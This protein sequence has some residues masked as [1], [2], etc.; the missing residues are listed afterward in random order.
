MA[1]S[2][3]SLKVLAPMPAPL[4]AGTCRLVLEAPPSRRLSASPSSEAFAAE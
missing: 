3:S 1:A 2:S 4:T